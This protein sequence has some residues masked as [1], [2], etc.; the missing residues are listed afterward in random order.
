VARLRVHGS[1]YFSIDE[2]KREAPSLQEGQSPNFSQVT[3]DLLV[4]NGLARSPGDAVRDRGEHS[5]HGRREFDVKDTPPIHGSI[6]LNN[7]YSADTTPLRVNGT[8]SYDISGSWS[9]RSASAFRSR[10][11]IPRT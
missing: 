1:R 7:R 8:V 5:R 2:I 9:I 6:E 4:L 11:K 10:R 3:H